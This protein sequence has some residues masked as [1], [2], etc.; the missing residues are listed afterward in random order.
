MTYRE[1][2]AQMTEEQLDQ[3]VMIYSVETD[4]FYGAKLMVADDADSIDEGH[5]YLVYEDV[6]DDSE[7]YAFGPEFW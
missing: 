6:I 3:Q 7:P 2:F 4:Y 5:I 1:M